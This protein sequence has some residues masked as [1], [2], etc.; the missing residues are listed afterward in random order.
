LSE[1]VQIE[2]LETGVFSVK[3]PEGN[4]VGSIMAEDSF[5]GGGGIREA[6]RQANYTVIVGEN[7]KEGLTLARAKAQAKEWLGEKSK[8]EA[9]VSIK[10]GLTQKGKAKRIENITQDI[11]EVRKK[12]NNQVAKWNSIPKE[13]RKSHPNL[14]KNIEYLRSRYNSLKEDLEMIQSTPVRNS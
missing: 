3:D 8:G 4:R 14:R 12:F 13:E 1:R 2:R 11:D 9:R 6:G 10:G 7:K 5:V